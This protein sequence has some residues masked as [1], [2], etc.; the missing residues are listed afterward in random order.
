MNRALDFRIYTCQVDELTQ[1]ITTKNLVSWATLSF[2]KL[3]FFRPAHLWIFSSVPA[4]S[5]YWQAHDSTLPRPHTHLILS[6]N[7]CV[8]RHQRRAACMSVGGFT[9][10]PCVGV[11]LDHVDAWAQPP[12]RALVEPPLGD[13]GGRLG[14]LAKCKQKYTLF[15]LCLECLCREMGLTGK[16]LTP[17]TSPH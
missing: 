10:L 6:R 11:V 17:S 12:S 5:H 9:W 7:P 15:V 13:P 1:T 14:L 8:S 16:E 4:C 2:Y 3:V